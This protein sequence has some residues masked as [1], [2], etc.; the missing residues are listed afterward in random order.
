[1]KRLL[2]L[3]L[4]APSLCLAQSV[5]IPYNPDA[6]D[7]GFIGSPDL[8]SLLPLFGT[9]FGI[10]SA[11]TCDYDGTPIEEFLGNVWN[12][13]IIIDSIFVQ[14][15]VID[16]AEIFTAGCPL[17]TWETVHYERAYMLRNF[18]ESGARIYWAAPYLGFTRYFYYGFDAETG[19]YQMW[20]QDN[21]V[22]DLSLTEVLGSNQAYALNSETGTQWFIPFPADEAEFDEG[23]LSI[24]SLDGFL[25]SASY[26]NILPYWHYAE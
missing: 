18:V 1:M 7:D 12:G 11:L 2:A 17:P 14:Y 10:D 25:S 26:V 8:L 20:I 21:E 19:V 5:T 24:A 15:E 4:F 22:Y 16:S 23:G 9:Q 6:N 3:L 13:D